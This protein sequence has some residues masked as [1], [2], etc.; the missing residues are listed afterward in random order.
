MEF[1][2]KGPGLEAGM[3]GFV[4]RN[5]FL[6]RFYEGSIEKDVSCI[7]VPQSQR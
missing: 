6:C 7:R 4:E 5:P 3:Q 2:V 1:G